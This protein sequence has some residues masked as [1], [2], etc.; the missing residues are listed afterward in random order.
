MKAFLFSP[1]RRTVFIIAGI[2]LLALGFGGFMRQFTEGSTTNTV[3][4]IAIMLWGVV[5]CLVASVPYS[6][7]LRYFLGTFTF[8]LS[9]VALAQAVDLR[10]MGRPMA[11][12]LALAVLLFLFGCHC[13]W[14][15]IRRHRRHKRKHAAS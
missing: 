15:G 8:S 5:L 10:L 2:A 11:P 4:C 3:L 9:A 13:Y 6:P 1:A 7:G 12:E 14:V